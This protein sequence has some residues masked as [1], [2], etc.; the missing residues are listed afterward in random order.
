[1]ASPIQ[2]MQFRGW[3]IYLKRDDLFSLGDES[4]SLSSDG[5]SDTSSPRN[6]PLGLSGNK[7]R[8]L[9][10]F[11]QADFRHIRRLVSYGS[12]Q[13]NMLYS[14][15]CLAQI[16]G[17]SLDFYT[18]HI[19][20]NLRNNPCGNYAAALANGAQI[21]ALGDKAADAGQSLGEFVRSNYAP[22]ADSPD[23]EA[24]FIPEGG[25]SDFAELGVQQL[26]AE[27][28]DWVV[29]KNLANPKVMLPSGTGTT[30]LYLQ[31]HLDFDVLTC[32]CVGSPEYLSRQF[33][34]LTADTSDHPKIL[35]PPAGVAGQV[36]K[37][38]F[39]KCYPEFYAIWHE[40]KEQ[41]GI[42]F[43]LLYDPLGWLSLLEYLN[44][45][46]SESSPNKESIIYLHQGGLLGNESMLP[47][48]KRQQRSA[49]QNG[50]S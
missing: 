43:E 38:H 41:T 17:W 35:P 19:A 33:N 20:Q 34:D 25:H 8:K 39:G 12:A 16:K 44:Q 4:A 14:L 11:L 37:Y 10:Y 24:L 23:S 36:K 1:M 50:P 15:S 5:N 47:R 3:P 49:Q 22:D 26:A 27:L 42:S 46:S 7:A 30:A 2:E 40:L 6:R 32:A 13:S 9:R 31:K 29:E 18:D 21:L 28:D 45:N 48:Y